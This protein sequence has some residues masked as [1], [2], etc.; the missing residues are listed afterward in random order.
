MS[1][2]TV[3]ISNIDRG[4]GIFTA[5]NSYKSRKINEQILN[6]QYDSNRH[7]SDLKRQMNEA[8][9]INKQILANQLKAEE[10]KE[11]QKYYKALSFNFF[12]TVDVISKIDDLM[13]LNYVF[14]KYYDKIKFNIID[15]NDRLDEIG[16]KTFNKQTLN[17]LQ[18]L[19][20]IADSKTSEFTGNT[21]NFI[22][23]YLADFKKEK[24]RIDSINK[25]DFKIEIIKRRRVN[26]LRTIT[27]GILGIFT[28][29]MAIGSIG[30]LKDTWDTTI[31]IIYIIIISASAIPFTLL[32]RKELK[33]RKEYDEFTNKEL[34]RQTDFEKRKIELEKQYKSTIL[35]E[36]ETLSNHPF[37]K[38]MIEINKNHPTF[39]KSLSAIIEIEETFV[40]KWGV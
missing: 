8:N 39:D 32:I 17:K 36:N 40:K 16:D 26:I 11:A 33:W 12:E 30:V 6:Q 15:A 10:H 22:D 29:I 19:K 1:A 4:I 27:I 28:I 20:I 13:V 34:K 3:R 31:L 23:N 5:V 35:N 38:A 25:P 2:E 21:L 24:A 37:C 18:S 14:T 7:L 9:A